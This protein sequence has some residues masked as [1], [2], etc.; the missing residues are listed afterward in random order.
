MRSYAG[1]VSS[2]TSEEHIHCWFK[3]QVYFAQHRGLQNLS[4]LVQAYVTKL[5]LSEIQGEQVAT[6][7]EFILST[8]DRKCVVHAKK[9]VILS[10][11]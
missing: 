6:G 9:E 8:E 10:A 1:S 3:F 7:V 5:V 4:V 11:G 2:Y